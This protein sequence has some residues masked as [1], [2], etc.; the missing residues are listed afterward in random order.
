ML[1]S[2][3][4]YNWVLLR[5][6]VLY[7]KFWYL[8]VLALDVAKVMDCQKVLCFFLWPYPK[9][10]FVIFCCLLFV[11]GCSVFFLFLDSIE[12]ILVSCWLVGSA[13]DFKRIFNCLVSASRRAFLSCNDILFSLMTA[14]KWVK[15]SLLNCCLNS[16][17][18]EVLSVSR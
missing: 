11:D 8:L 6:K 4:L 18:R 14:V 3:W 15:K 16:F 9:K 10:W 17:W 2:L 7:L 13:V 5:R 1:N 12:M